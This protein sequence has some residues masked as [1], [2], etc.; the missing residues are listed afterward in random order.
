MPSAGTAQHESAQAL[1]EFTDHTAAAAVGGTF[2]IS[3]WYVSCGHLFGGEI[4][5][6]SNCTHLHYASFFCGCL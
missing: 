1:V 4:P 5:Q 3:D 6:C 2:T